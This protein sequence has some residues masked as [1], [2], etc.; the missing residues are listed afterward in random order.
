MTF[1]QTKLFDLNSYPY[2]LEETST[3]Q[4][5]GTAE[6][7]VSG[8]GP[9]LGY[10]T[11]VYYLVINVKLGTIYLKSVPVSWSEIM[12][13]HLPRRIFFKGCKHSSFNKGDPFRGVVVF[14]KFCNFWCK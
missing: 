3:K 4:Q 6:E 5:K 10:T 8:P 7:E 13:P 9:E 14:I 2:A 11:M 1:R 12:K